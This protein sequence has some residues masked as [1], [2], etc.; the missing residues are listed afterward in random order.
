MKTMSRTEIQTLTLAEEI[1]AAPGG[2]GIRVCMQCGTCT[3][4][5]PNADLMDHSPSE[6]IAMARAGLKEEVLS[7]KAPWYCLSCY[8]CT[9][10]CPRDVKITRLMHVLEGLAEKYKLSS[11]R[12]TTPVI[13]GGFNDFIYN[14]GRMSEL[15][16][17]VR[18]Y[19]RTNPLKAIKMAPL[20]L[21]LL[22][23]Q[24]IT[25]KMGKISPQAVKQL[26]AIID[27]AESFGG[28]L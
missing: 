25:V 27:K 14:R 3:A 9:V 2:E 7:S 13:Y 10:R 16:V 11:K 20:A 12:T 21:S 4:S 28:S 6:L 8:L 19:M 5:C 1:A 15:W 17:M 22:T 23:H 24:R 18:Y 26:Q